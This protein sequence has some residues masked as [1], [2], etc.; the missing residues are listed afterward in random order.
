MENEK[1]PG[2]KI[3][4]LIGV[5]LI[6]SSVVLGGSSDA[7]QD[8]WVAM[9][10]AMVVAFLLAWLYS[11][12]LRLHPGKNMFVIFS[13][14][15]GN[16]GGKIVSGLYV[17]YAI[18]LG[19]RMFAIYDD[20][21]HIV[22]LEATPIAA[23]LLILVPLI[24]GLVK[25]GLKNMASCAKFLYVVI[26]LTV[27]TTLGLG[28]QFMKLDNIRPILSTKPDTMLEAIGIYLM[29]PMGEI[30]LS[31]A[32]F[33]EVDK[34]ESP[35]RIFAKGI[36]LGGTVLLVAILR[37]LL[38]VGA[39]TCR[40]LLFA[41]YDAVGIIS[42][43]DFVTRISVVI[44]VNLTLAGGVKVSAFAYSASLGAAEII[45]LKKL[46][47]IAAPCC[48]LMA[49]LSFTF[50]TDILTA[51]KFIKGIVLIGVPFQIVLPIVILI[52]G[53]IRLGKKK[54]GA[55]KKAAPA[56]PPIEASSE[57]D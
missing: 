54:K 49:A 19:A 33:G 48:V 10:V 3:S 25:C 55:A 35:F 37:N 17:A 2:D 50:F 11:S 43:G 40:M 47:K 42:I 38:L 21:I 27:V 13:E 6:G 57:S 34:K 4:A 51:V 18:F 23:I 16:V 32:F 45:G 15:F 24:A 36:L 7:K 52:V 9:L 56:P 14:V 53:K 39:P 8:T 26:V 28:F 29:L 1:V 46:R 41:S 31:M 12:I 44:G 5:S 22:N 30:V 20:F